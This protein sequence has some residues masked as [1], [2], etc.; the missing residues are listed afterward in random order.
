M[1]FPVFIINGFLDSGKTTFIIDTL[2]NENSLKGCFV[3]CMTEKMIFCHC[4]FLNI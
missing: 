4:F 3:R 2:K 1:A